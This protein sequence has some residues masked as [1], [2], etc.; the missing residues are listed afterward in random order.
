MSL[1]NKSVFLMTKLYN[2]NIPVIPR[3]M[4]QMNRLIF[5]T[6]IPRSVKIGEGTR[7][8][9]SGLGCVIHERTIIGKNCK[10]LQ[11]VTMGGRGK[12]GT[13]VIGDNVLIGDNA[14]IGAQA[15]VMEDVGENQTIVANKG[16]ILNN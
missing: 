8:A 4:Q 2:K 9:H 10:I 3:A 11:N 14:K 12:H 16:T 7:F 13:P 5:A 15:L 6:D 1:M